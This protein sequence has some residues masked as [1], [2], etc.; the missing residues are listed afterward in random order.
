MSSGFSF[1]SPVDHCHQLC[2]NTFSVANLIKFALFLVLVSFVWI[3]CCV[4]IGIC[5]IWVLLDY[6]SRSLHND[7]NLT[8][9][10]LS[11][12][13][14]MPFAVFL[15]TAPPLFL[16]FFIIMLGMSHLPGLVVILFMNI[17]GLSLDVS[18]LVYPLL[19][20]FLNLYVQEDWKSLMKL[21]CGVFFNWLKCMHC[22]CCPSV[23]PSQI[24]PA[25]DSMQLQE[26]A[27]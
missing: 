4:V 7:V 10:M 2:T 22:Q 8:K 9:K 13:V 21:G 23:S 15:L 5:Y 12:P 27:M 18:G 14:F 26:T 1:G 17:N 16:S 20:L 6:Q 3:P 11:L 24:A 19:L 25:Q